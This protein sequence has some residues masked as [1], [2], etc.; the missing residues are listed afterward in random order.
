MHS[1]FH[2]LPTHPEDEDF[3]EIPSEFDSN[4]I[5]LLNYHETPQFSSNLTLRK[6]D[7]P[8]TPKKPNN[9]QFFNKSEQYLN[10]RKQKIGNLKAEIEQKTMADC[11]FKPSIN[12]SKSRSSRNF[13]QFLESQQIHQ[14][15]IDEK[16]NT[17]KQRIE[18]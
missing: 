6:N 7:H 2:T 3:E 15:K 17:L 10:A 11:T 1:H 9:D 5:T 12:R 14:L 16:N 8:L 13:K 18:Y 4:A